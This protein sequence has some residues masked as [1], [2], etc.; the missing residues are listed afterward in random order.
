MRTALSA[1][2]SNGPAPEMPDAADAN[3]FRPTARCRAMP[4]DHDVP[5]SPLRSTDTFRVGLALGAGGNAGSAFIANALEHLGGAT[6][7]DPARSSRIVGTSAGAFRAARVDPAP[8]SVSPVSDHMAT[9][10]DVGETLS[11]LANGDEWLP[12]RSDPA[13]RAV[14]AIAGRLV[15]LL[16]PT[17][18]APP[19]WSVA[20]APFHHE[21]DV[22][23]V[24]LRSGHRRVHR[25]T[26][27]DD[28]AT[29]VLASGAVPGM[30]QPVW[31]EGRRH[32]DGAV[33]SPTNADLLGPDDLDLLIVVAPM[34]PRD[35]GNL[36]GR[37]HRALL[38]HEL[39]AW[40]GAARP[41]VV[42]APSGHD[43]RSRKDSDRFATTA[44]P[45]TTRLSHRSPRGPHREET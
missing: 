45:A 21:A 11:S 28:P 42:I 17:S 27:I 18:G 26:A 24:E 35:G 12:R 9:P 40:H 19:S 44:G 16:A 6:G 20:P 13:V 38:R 22:V 1:P 29:A 36:V 31:I 30:T 4:E 2:F 41:V 15:A 33:Y 23:T 5:M 3:R 39:R 8:P 34:V 37:V 32:I 7:F 43:R 25:L 10:I 14:R